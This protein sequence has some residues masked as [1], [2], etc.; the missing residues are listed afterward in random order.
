MKGTSAGTSADLLIMMYMH[1]NACVSVCFCAHFASSYSDRCIQVDLVEARGIQ[2]ETWRRALGYPR[3]RKTGGGGG[4]GDWLTPWQMKTDS[5]ASKVS[6]R[7]WARGDMGSREERGPR[8]TLGGEGMR[9]EETVTTK[10]GALMSLGG[11]RV[12]FVWPS[13]ANSHP[14]STPVPL[15]ITHNCSLWLPLAFIQC[16]PALFSHEYFRKEGIGSDLLTCRSPRGTWCRGLVVE[17]P[18]TCAANRSG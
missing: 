7:H 10:S 2:V 1:L 6:S 5:G 3:G 9:E 13:Q 17:G 18:S 12:F 8:N 4:G 14:S 11:G 15:W 16:G